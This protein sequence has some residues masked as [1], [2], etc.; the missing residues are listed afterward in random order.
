MTR[1]ADVRP[2]HAT[3][4]A[5]RIEIAR[6]TDHPN[7]MNGV[8]VGAGAEIQVGHNVIDHRSAEDFQAK[9]LSWREYHWTS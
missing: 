8:G 2:P 7:A 9:R 3:G 5:I 6:A 1:D 4:V